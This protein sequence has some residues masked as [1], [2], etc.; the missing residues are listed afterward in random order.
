MGVKIELKNMNKQKQH[1]S[2]PLQEGIFKVTVRDILTDTS[3]Q[4][5]HEPEAMYFKYARDFLKT[6]LAYNILCCHQD[7]PNGK[8]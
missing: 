4:L 5:T 8:P 1:I 7:V 2:L 6:S 3:Y